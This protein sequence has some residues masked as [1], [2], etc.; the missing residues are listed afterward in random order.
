MHAHTQ[1]YRPKYLGVSKKYQ[2]S[3]ERTKIVRAI[4]G[5]IV[6]EIKDLRCFSHT[7]TFAQWILSAFMCESYTCT[8]YVN[9]GLT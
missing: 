5:A 1:R 8:P 7:L 3:F 6:M 2:S 4:C 9:Y